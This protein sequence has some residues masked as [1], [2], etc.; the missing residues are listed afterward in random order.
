MNK[1]LEMLKSDLSLEYLEESKLQCQEFD[2]IEYST[3]I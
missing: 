3:L 2:K 1:N